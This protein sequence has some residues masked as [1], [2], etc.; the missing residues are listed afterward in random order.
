[1][2]LPFG[3]TRA[4]AALAGAAGA[5]AAGAAAGA[6]AGLAAGAWAAGALVGADGAAG[7]QASRRPA[8]TESLAVTAIAR[9]CFQRRPWA[10][11]LTTSVAF[12]C[13]TIVS[14]FSESV[15]GCLS[16]GS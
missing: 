16:T 2:T 13:T 3:S 6:E 7:A 1:M 11:V 15:P 8:S 12:G 14:P 4:G 5:G 9:Q 10:S